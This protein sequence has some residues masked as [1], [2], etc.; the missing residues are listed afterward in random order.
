MGPGVL[1]VRD[2]EFRGGLGRL[3]SQ[4][5]AAGISM[6]ARVTLHNG[7]RTVHPLPKPQPLLEAM[8]H[9]G[10]QRV[11]ATTQR[12]EVDGRQSVRARGDA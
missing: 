6:G 1:T 7:S 2:T 11:I 3:A 8:K 10:L 4:S 9:A 5:A 12:D